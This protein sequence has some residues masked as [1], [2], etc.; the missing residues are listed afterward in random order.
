VVDQ[1]LRA[2]GW[3][4]VVAHGRVSPGEASLEDAARRAGVHLHPIEQMGRRVSPWSDLTV[5]IRLLRLMRRVQPDVVHTHTAKAGALGRV[6]AALYNGARSPRRRCLIVHTFHGHVM[7]G[8]FGSVANRLVRVTERGLAS[9]TDR[10]VTIS[11]R[12]RQDIVARYRIAAAA[13]VRVVPL[14]FELE[15]LLDLPEAELAR[16]LLGVPS[17]ALVIGFIGRLVS[18][19]QP[20]ALVDAFA[21]LSK[22]HPH[23]VLLVVGDGDLRPAV[24][25]DVARRGLT[26][27][28]VFAGW[29]EDLPTIYAAVD[30]VALTSRNEGTPVALIEA[31]AAARPVVATD[32]G[33]VADLVEDGDTG[34]IVPLDD[35][36]ALIDALGRLASDPEERRRLGQNGRARVLAGYRAD[37]L[38]DDLDRLYRSGLSHKRDLIKAGGLPR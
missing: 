25:R 10:V 23:A 20:L 11:D 21:G 24:E 19:K 38:A 26:R 34:F 8:Y 22:S 18:I 35:Q 2:R 17:D 7:H 37:R 36:R 4:T 32:V 28:V 3:E 12:Q 6:A 16:R 5:L 9:V 33:G 29:R 30:I 27:Q 13:K 1:R 15:P 31:M 14:G